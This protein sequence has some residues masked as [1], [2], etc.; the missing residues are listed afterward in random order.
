[1]TTTTRNTLAALALTLAAAGPAAAAVDTGNLALD[2]QSAVSG[3]GIVNVTV[4]DGVATLTGSASSSSRIAAERTA[5][6][7][8]GVEEVINLIEEGQ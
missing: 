4:N 2:V 5:L 7:H 3:D 8:E 6:R 1:M